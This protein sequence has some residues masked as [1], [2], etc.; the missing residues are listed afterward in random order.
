MAGAVRRPARLWTSL[1]GPLARYHHQGCVA[2]IWGC[3]LFAL[4][5]VLNSGTAVCRTE[6]NASTNEAMR[7][8]D[9]A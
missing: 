1:A 7:N 5:L 4:R 3:Y 6:V 2:I 9:W 8:Y